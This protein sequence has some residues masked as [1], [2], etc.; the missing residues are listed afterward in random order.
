[1]CSATQVEQRQDTLKKIA[2]SKYLSVYVTQSAACVLCILLH[3]E[4]GNKH[5]T[6]NQRVF[7]GPLWSPAAPQVI[8]S[9]TELMS[10]QCSLWTF[11]H[12]SATHVITCATCGLAN[13]TILQLIFSVNMK[14]HLVGATHANARA[15]YAQSSI[16]VC[17][18][19]KLLSCN[20]RLCTGQYSTR[21]SQKYGGGEPSLYV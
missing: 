10:L 11:Y 1:M 13:C 15:P 6:N 20:L 7:C 12:R 21:R 3:S 4:P 17:V 14:I 18:F 9:F 16:C 8:K 5:L 2:R 19:S